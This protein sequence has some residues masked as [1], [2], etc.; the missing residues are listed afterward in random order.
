VSSYSNFDLN[1]NKKLSCY[2]LGGVMVRILALRAK[3]RGFEP[4]QGDGFFKALKISCTPSLGSKSDGPH[5]TRFYA[6]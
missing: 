2:P 3:V 1:L 5:V 4:G 6:M